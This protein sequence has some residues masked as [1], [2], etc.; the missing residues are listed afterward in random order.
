[1]TKQLSL[2]EKWGY[3]VA[4]IGASL[5]YNTINFFLLFFLVEI[6][7][8]GPALA[9]LALL[10]GRLFDAF[11]DPVMG[12]ITDRTRS[13]WGRRK[14]YIWIGAVPF[15]ISFAL[16]WTIPEGSHLAVFAL[17]A[18][19]LWLHILIYT[20]VQVPYMA[21]TPELAPEYS[22]RTALT[23]YRIGFGTLASLIG[24]AVPPLLISTFNAGQGLPQDARFGWIGM[25][26]VFGIL[27][28]LSYLTM[29]A[30]VRE[31]TGQLEPPGRLE[32]WREYRSVFGAFGFPQV[33]LIFVAVTIGLGVVSSI[34]PF[35]LIS[36]I[37]LSAGEQTAILGL[38]FGVAILVLPVWNLVSARVGKKAAFIAGLLTL[39]L[40]LVLLVTLSPA[41]WLSPLLLF[42]TVFAGIGTATVLLF[43]WAMIPD[44]VEFDEL[45]SGKR[46]EGLLYSIFTFGQKT[47]FA[48]GAFLNAM[49]L[50][51][52][53]YDREAV[54]QTAQAVSGIQWMVG[55]V[56]ALM[57]FL[58]AL[59][60]W[61]YPITKA[62]H[63]EARAR[64][65]Q[66][67]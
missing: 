57:F 55:P 9:G 67:R 10:S 20:T 23:S 30:L 33:L 14:P 63:D 38:L 12:L 7:G 46:R 39:S 50:E 45:A 62:R 6:V 41:G 42:F 22:Q 4:D 5:S 34:L 66:R 44:V 43:P 56:A 58:A 40:S 24:A 65:A 59:L 60:V 18:L 35:Y 31:R 26:I 11:T 17:A 1:M 47:A 32:L 36:A 52:V 49:M 15:G 53:G 16:L 8:L 48:L 27:M 28:S 54:V 37:A 29:A 21:L 3:G 2:R 19:A 25:G 51:L 61:R 13:R 64:L